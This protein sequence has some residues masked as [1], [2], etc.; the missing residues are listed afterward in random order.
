MFDKGIEFKKGDNS[1]GNTMCFIAKVQGKPA[2]ILDNIEIKSE[3]QYSDELRDSIIDFAR[4]LCKE[5]GNPKM[6]IYAGTNKHGLNFEKFPILKN[7][8]IKI[9]GQADDLIY[10]ET[11]NGETEVLA[12][13]FKYTDLIKISN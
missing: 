7:S 9:L 8:F 12:N 3:Y 5:I 2:L 10:I 11:L 6:P 4:K 1:I 13:Q